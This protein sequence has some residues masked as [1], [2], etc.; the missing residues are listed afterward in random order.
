MDTSFLKSMRM[1]E[2]TVS[3]WAFA[4]AVFL[5]A[6]TAALCFFADRARAKHEK[7]ARELRVSEQFRSAQLRLSETARNLISEADRVPAEAFG[8]AMKTKAAN[9]GIQHSAKAAFS[10]RIAGASCFA[11]LYGCLGLGADPGIELSERDEISREIFAFGDARIPLTETKI[12]PPDSRKEKSWERV[13]GGGY[14]FDP[15]KSPV[16]LSKRQPRHGLWGETGYSVSAM[17]PKEVSAGSF[18]AEIFRG[19]LFLVREIRAPRLGAAIQGF[20]LNKEK[21]LAALRADV[22][23]FAPGA[24]LDFPAGTDTANILPAGIPLVLRTDGNAATGFLSVESPR[25]RTILTGIFVCVAVVCAGTLAAF[26]LTLKNAEQRRIFSA[27]VAHD[28]RTP[29]AGLEAQISTLARR[30]SGNAEFASEISRVER[31]AKNLSELLENV[32]MFSRLSFSSKNALQ[33]LN[34]RFGKIAEPICERLAEKLERGGCDFDAEFSDAARQARLRVSPAAL[35]R[36][37]SNIADNAATHARKKDDGAL[38]FTLSAH[39]ENGVF[40]LRAKDNGRG[41][42]PNAR[43]NIFSEVPVNEIPDGRLGLGI[44]L[45]LSRKLARMMGG[46]LRLEETGSAGTVFLLTLNVLK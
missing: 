6:A 28:L 36:I 10:F 14:F 17:P 32:L 34:V 25:F 4:A 31:N 9:F 43:K 44:G 35:E 20:L 24:R 22:A 42:P 27:A 1:R 5:L 16:P 11:D 21:L 45:A 3:R 39:A 23:E 15:E 18:H 30:A 2:K 41:L 40:F 19:N 12:I 33:L 46:D 26:R 13:C 7:T 38:I 29:V 8:D 37:L